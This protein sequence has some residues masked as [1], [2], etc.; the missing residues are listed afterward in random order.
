MSESSPK[1]SAP[2][3]LK[4]VEAIAAAMGLELYAQRPK[5]ITQLTA[6]RALTE[7]DGFPAKVKG[8]W[9]RAFIL[10][11]GEKG[12]INFLFWDV[13]MRTWMALLIAALLGFAAGYLVARLSRRRRHQD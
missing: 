3:W 7:T 11:N 8:Y 6:A 4:S 1:S 2:R 12:T 5:K 9:P 13:T 10:Q